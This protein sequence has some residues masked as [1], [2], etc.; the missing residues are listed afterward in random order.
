[1]IIVIFSG[2]PGKVYSEVPIKEVLRGVG[3][4]VVKGYCIQCELAAPPLSH[5]CR[6][7]ESCFHHMDHHCLFLNTCIAV[8]NHWHFVMF[9]ITNFILQ[10]TFSI[11]ALSIAPDHISKYSGPEYVEKMLIYLLEDCN[12]CLLLIV[13]NVAS[14]MWAFKLFK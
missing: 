7:C 14:A 10:I 3:E 13:A 4:E 12:W 2:N 5:H 11:T 9:I 8:N 6:L 1:M